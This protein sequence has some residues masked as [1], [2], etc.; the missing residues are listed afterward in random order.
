MSSFLSFFLSLLRSY[1]RRHVSR[2][3]ALL[4]LPEGGGGGWHDA[5]AGARER[6]DRCHG[7]KN[8]D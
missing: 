3:R 1:A 4:S 8:G 6:K 5:S 7:S 2:P